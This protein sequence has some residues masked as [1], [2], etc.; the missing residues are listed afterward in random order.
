MHN[1]QSVD[2]SQ[3]GFLDSRDHA[4]CTSLLRLRIDLGDVQS[5][6]PDDVLRSTGRL[7]P[8]H[9][10]HR[11]GYIVRRAERVQNVSKM[12]NRGLQDSAAPESSCS[13]KVRLLGSCNVSPILL[14]S[15]GPLTCYVF[16]C[17]KKK[18]KN[19]DSTSDLAALINHRG[20]QQMDSLAS[21]LAAKYG[22]KGKGVKG[23]KA[24]KPVEEPSEEEFLAAQK[25]VMKS[26]K[27]VEEP[28]EEQFLAAQ[29][30]LKK[31]S[32]R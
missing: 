5:V 8:V 13:S 12:G 9:G 32:K 15:C 21:A 25:R 16:D 6:Q 28:S 22:N 24:S 4:H 14:L 1:Y 31:K 3:L 11:C 30:R 29:K 27:S 19:G 20:K 26:D 7:P 17:R 18:K 2:T 10:H 23:G